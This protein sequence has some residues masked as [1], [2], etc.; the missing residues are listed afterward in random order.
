MQQAI[1]SDQSPGGQPLF[2]KMKMPVLIMLALIMAGGIYLRTCTWAG[3]ADGF[4]P[5][6]PRQMGFDESLYIDYVK[7][8]SDKGIARYPDF[9]ALFLYEQ[10]KRSSAILPPTRFLYI[11]CGALCYACGVT[12]LIR[13]ELAFLPTVA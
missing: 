1:P 11:F 2:A 4:N 6:K 9:C 8:L 5:S 7:L 3:F 13:K 12:A 10:E